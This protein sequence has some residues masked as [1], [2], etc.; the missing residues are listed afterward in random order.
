M[1]DQTL[2]QYVPSPL[3]GLLRCTRQLHASRFTATAGM[4]L[5]LD[6][7]CSTAEFDGRRFGLF[8]RCRNLSLGHGDTVALEDFLGLI[9]VN[10]HSFTPITNKDP[11]TNLCY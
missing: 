6:D 3:F 9:L 4:D 11:K 10:I 7:A 1:R 2:P 5:R 8:R